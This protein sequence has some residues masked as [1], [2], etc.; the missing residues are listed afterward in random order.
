MAFHNN[1]D[2]CKLHDLRASGPKYKWRGLVFQGGKHIYDRLDRA[3]CNEDL[4]L[5]FP[6]AYTKVLTRFEFS[7]HHP[8]MISL[9]CNVYSKVAKHFR[10]K[11]AWLVDSNYTDRL[12]GLW[13]D[14]KGLG[15]KL[16][17]I[18]KDLK[19]WKCSSL[20]QVH[21]RKKEIMA[22]LNGVQKCIQRREN[23]GACK[24]L[25]LCCKMS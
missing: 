11:S 15:H 7:D 1:I 9:S 23:M 12:M 5:K 24:L 19:A 21:I 4:S 2:D 17:N 3:L 16:K 13:K 10:F 14:N 22:R 25:S 6:E 20:K 8:I 18:T